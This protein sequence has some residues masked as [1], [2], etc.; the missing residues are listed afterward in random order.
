[1]IN[2][3]QRSP[4]GLFLVCHHDSSEAT[5]RLGRDP[6]V[7]PLADIDGPPEI[8]A[9]V[10][11]FNNV[12]ARLKLYVKD[13]TTMV[14]AIA[15]DLRTPLMRLTLLLEN[16]PSDMKSAAEAEIKEMNSR[17][18]GALAFGRDAGNPGRR[19]CLELRTLVESVVDEMADR[20]ADVAVLPGDELTVNADVAGLRALLVN[21]VENAVRYAD[22]ARAIATPGQP[23]PDRSGGQ[24]T[25]H[26]S[27]GTGE[28]VRTILPSG[29]I[30]QPGDRRHRPW[31]CQRQGGGKESRR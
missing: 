26:S 6:T 9:A 1:M 2:D 19:Q 5:E 28:G 31:P 24:W 25:G 3:Q 7:P 20:G 29:S 12:Q 10:V 27:A 11:A 21:L 17:I 16:V 8:A 15:H 18:R 14:A 30:T 22:G 13:R 4:Y 23:D